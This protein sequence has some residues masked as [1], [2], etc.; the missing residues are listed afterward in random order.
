MNIVSLPFFLFVAAVLAAYYLVPKRFQWVVLLLSS[1]LFYCSYGWWKIAFL[2][3]PSLV[4]YGCGR[5][6]QRIQQQNSANDAKKKSKP[7]C[8]LGVVA[9]L[10]LLL[11]AKAGSLLLRALDNIIQPANPSVWIVVS[12]GVSY[13]SFSL[14]S[15]IVDVY[16]RRDE[17]EQDFFRFLLYAIYFPKVLQGPIVKHRTIRDALFSE[18]RFQPRVCLRGLERMLWGYFKKLVI[19]DRLSLLLN[20]V[21]GNVDSVSGPVVCYAA[22]C[23]VIQLYCDFSGCM[24]ILGGISQCFMVELEK[25]FDHPFRSESAAEFWRRWHITLG[26]WFKDY[27]FRPL[28]LSKWLLDAAK[29]ARAS[30]GVSF[31]RTFTTAVPLLTVWIL[32]GLWH[33]LRAEYLIWGL[34]WGVVIL[35]EYIIGMNTARKK[36]G[37]ERR[38][39]G[40]GLRIW[41]KRCGVWLLFTVSRLL[42]A[43]GDFR[44][45]LKAFS[46]LIV[47]NRSNLPVEELLG[48]N[49]ANMILVFLSTV[50]LFLV[51][52]YDDA[53]GVHALLDRQSM[54]RRLSFDFLFLLAVVIFGC[55]GM[56]YDPAAFVY[57]GY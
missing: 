57:M 23:S 3:A 27:V 2:L 7:V 21:W 25:N 19:A 42:T 6:I 5:S 1:I 22:V 51:E 10:A 36:V 24:D 48:L 35:A 12:L 8:T 45:S 55:Y 47:L 41:A 52:H 44:T 30:F 56:G 14:I 9:V 13:Y 15:Y 4:S 33:N 26:E 20:T 43:P 28:S 53:K 18:H 11:Y 39:D 31:S 46:R 49:R 16:R 38:S 37:A 17:A 34:Y 54:Y 50:C 40:G 29:K 32:T